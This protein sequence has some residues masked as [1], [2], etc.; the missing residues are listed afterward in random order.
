MTR[1]MRGYFRTPSIS[2]ISPVILLSVFTIATDPLELTR[3]SSRIKKNIKRKNLVKAPASTQRADSSKGRLV[4][5]R[6]P[7]PSSS[8]YAPSIM[9][10]RWESRHNLDLV[11]SRQR[12]LLVQP[13]RGRSLIRFILSLHAV[14]E[15]QQGTASTLQHAL[16]FQTE[17]SH[18]IR[19][20][21]LG[22]SDKDYNCVLVVKEE[23]IGY[24][25]F[26]PS[27]SISS[28]HTAEVLALWTFFL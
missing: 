4:Y 27:E 12:V 11:L 10:E 20:I 25:L 28:E 6:M 22:E 16:Y 3:P 15:D 24:C 7:S 9:Q 18:P 8:F 26:E 13:M 17:P 14:Q 2:C 19:L 21:F 23:I 1:W 5:R